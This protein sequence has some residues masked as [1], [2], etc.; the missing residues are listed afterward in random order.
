LNG[1]NTFSRDVCVVGGG[2]HVGLP[3]ALTF[4][5]SGLKTVIYDINRRV[6]DAIKSGQMPFTEEGAQEILDRVLE[7]GA[8]SAF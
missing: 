1:P 7:N 5:D 2:G 3:L 6:V 4:A 8:L